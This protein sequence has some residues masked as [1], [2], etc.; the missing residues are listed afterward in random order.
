MW[1]KLLGAKFLKDPQNESALAG[2]NHL[3]K[4]RSRKSGAIQERSLTKLAHRDCHRDNQRGIIFG[5]V[6]I[7]AN[8]YLLYSKISGNFHET[9]R[10]VRRWFWDT[11]LNLGPNSTKFQITESKKSQ[12]NSVATWRVSVKVAGEVCRVCRHFVGSKVTSV[13]YQYCT[14][15]LSWLMINERVVKV[16][17][18][19][20]SAWRSV[21][22][23]LKTRRRVQQ[24]IGRI[25]RVIG[26]AYI[27]QVSCWTTFILIQ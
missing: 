26:T 9:V 7:V 2:A 21:T 24:L 8:C 1:L 13:W 14:W 3:V 10:T 15:S 23:P 6:C 18:T 17:Q 4:D 19:N 22:P 27:R 25:G 5:G 20:N 12:R 11:L 16:V